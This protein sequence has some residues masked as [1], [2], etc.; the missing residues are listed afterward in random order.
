MR[1]PGMQHS[2]FEAQKAYAKTGDKD[3]EGLLIDILVERAANN[4]RNLHQIV[5][6]ESLVVAPKL[7]AEH[8]DALS[9]NF[10][11]T[12]TFD[13]TMN[14]LDSLKSYLERI[15]YPFL[16]TLHK[17]TLCYSHLQYLGC[18]SIVDKTLEMNF[19]ERYP[20]LF[21]KGF[22]EEEF[23]KGSPHRIERYKSL[24]M[25]HMLDKDKLQYDAVA[26]D[27][28][29]RD[30]SDIKDSPQLKRGILQDYHHKR[31]LM[32][33]ELQPFLRKISPAADRLIGLWYG[34]DLSKIRLTPVGIAIAVANVRR[35]LGEQLDLSTWITD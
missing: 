29:S 13:R 35:R 11:L 34:S 17:D 21:C 10:M 12:K 14:S 25:P 4:E 5:L 1:D 20:N 27:K 28:Y 26:V 8:M 18:A 9:V 33:Q 3:L 2:L 32:K 6:D 30:E 16:G 19:F 23:N 15:I 24:L 7:T 31:Q 22:T